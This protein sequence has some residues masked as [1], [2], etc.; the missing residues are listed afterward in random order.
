MRAKHAMQ[1]F[2]CWNRS[3][4]FFFLRRLKCAFWKKG[5]FPFK[6]KER[7]KICLTTT[8]ST[9]LDSTDMPDRER[10]EKSI[11]RG[12]KMIR[13]AKKFFLNFFF[14]HP[15]SFFLLYNEKERNS[16]RSSSTR[17]FV[18]RMVRM[19][20]KDRNV[21]STAKD[22]RFFFIAM[23]NQMEMKGKREKNVCAGF[24]FPTWD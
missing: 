10:V 5:K 7:K 12:T 4:S 6:T 13:L 18:P 24:L 16:F 8:F 11:L 21:L 9:K 19:N 17:H 2:R 14:S 23:P 15:H 22:S 20:N 1:P 3:I